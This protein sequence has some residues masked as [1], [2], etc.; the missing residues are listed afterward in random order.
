MQNFVQ[1]KKEILATEMP[2][3]KNEILASLSK[4]SLSSTLHVKV[5]NISFQFVLQVASESTKNH[6]QN[7]KVFFLSRRLFGKKTNPTSHSLFIATFQA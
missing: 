2:C 7:R 4:S 3:Y 1:G 5:G 6:N